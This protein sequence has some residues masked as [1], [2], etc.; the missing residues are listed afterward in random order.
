MSLAVRFGFLGWYS[1]HQ[2][3]EHASNHECDDESWLGYA[4]LFIALH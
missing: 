3:L 2:R 1:M 4:L